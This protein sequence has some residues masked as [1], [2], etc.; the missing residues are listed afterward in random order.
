MKIYLVGPTGAGKTT[1]GQILASRLRLP[2]LDADELIAVRAGK[3]IG[4]IFARE[5]EQGFRH[6]E[7]EAVRVIAELG[8]AVVALGGGAV[9]DPGV[10]ELL[11][12]SGRVVALEEDPDVLVERIRRSPRPG[13]PD[14]SHPAFAGEAR[15]AVCKRMDAVRGLGPAVTVTGLGPEEAAA[16][17]LAGL[18]AGGG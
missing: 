11:G 12:R 8:S 3:S 10:R 17:V 9:L 14:P 5:G 16:R 2:F 18:G 6:R 1:I 4:D 15:R 7:R 13:L